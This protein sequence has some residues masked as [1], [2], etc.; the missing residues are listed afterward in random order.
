MAQ[1]CIA[2]GLLLLLVCVNNVIGLC[3][4]S[5]P[6]VTVPSSVTVKHGSTVNISSDSFRII[7]SSSYQCKIYFISTSTYSCGIVSPDVFDCNSFGHFS[8]THY[9]CD[10]ETENLDFAV[11][12]IS[13][14]QTVL[15]TKYVSVKVKVEDDNNPVLP[16][17]DKIIVPSDTMSVSIPLKLLAENLTCEYAIVSPMRLPYYG[18]VTGPTSL[19]LAC[20]SSHTF[21]Y[22]LHSDHR[23]PQSE[24]RVVAA[25]RFANSNTRFVQIRVVIDHANNVES[26]CSNTQGVLPLS[27]STYTPVNIEHLLP[28][29]SVA[30]ERDWKVNI[31]KSNHLVIFAI[32][33]HGQHVSTDLFTIEQLQNGLVTLCTTMPVFP[34]VPAPSEHHYTIHDVYGRP[35]FNGSVITRWTPLETHL[36]QVST[37][38]GINVLEGQSVRVTSDILEFI[39][40]NCSDLTI[41]IIEPPKH[42][43]FISAETNMTQ[44]EFTITKD[45]RRN[46]IFNHSGD[47]NFADRAIWEIQCYGNNIGK[48]LQ[49]IRVTVLD[50]SPP[51]LVSKSAMSVHAYEIVQI[52]LIELQASDVD[53]CDI[54]IRY[55]ISQSNGTLFSSKKEALNGS[56][57]GLLE[58]TQ[59]DIDSGNVWYRPPDDV[60]IMK[61]II[62]FSLSDNSSPPNVLSNQQLKINILKPMNI[63]AALEMPLNSD[64]IMKMPVV[65]IG[66]VTLLLPIHFS[67]FTEQ[68]SWLK[69]TVVVPPESGNLSQY[70]FTLEDLNMN[71]IVYRHYG[72]EH[73]CKDNFIFQMSNSSG[74]QLFGKLVIA[75]VNLNMTHDVSL[76]VSPL[77]FSNIRPALATNSITVLDSPVCIDHLLFNIETA[78]R[79][80]TLYINKSLCSIR[81]LGSG[82]WFSLQDVRNGFVT[83][84]HNSSHYNSSN[85][86]YVDEF[87]FSL[88][89][90]VGRL[91]LNGD[92]TIR[93]SIVYTMVDPVVVLRSPSTLY[94]CHSSSNYCYNLSSVNIDVKSQVA[95]DS[96]IIIDVKGLPSYGRLM[97]TNGRQSNTFT[98]L[99]LRNKEVIYEIDL[100][101][102]QNAISNDSFTFFVRVAAQRVKSQQSYVLTL[103]WNYIF[104]EE[105]KLEV[106]ETD[107][108]FSVTVR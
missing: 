7:F 83:Y 1:M 75:M 72:V 56:G 28:N 16:V 27:F 41:S 74:A 34:E 105:P 51:F 10:K 43:Q 21:E 84:E 57:N 53:S 18:N 104:M 90:P 29:C 14:N 44:T 78:P 15:N 91:T 37:N 32:T 99:E 33:S 94:P 96:E 3:Q 92:T 63:P 46:I 107:G 62:L 13:S 87:T 17:F 6:K 11:Y 70:Q 77:G 40:H 60:T 26:S 20:N 42:G 88:S 38:D 79:I 50:D 106:N 100:S 81:K 22:S 36:V 93:Y 4:P 97:N 67:W 76:Q 47:D 49:P 24:D 59:S 85:S 58:F 30:V 52:S 9:G 68:F 71:R 61:D 101:L 45:L 82:S 108:E 98:M 66:N 73:S 23:P 12:L 31:T 55:N 5:Q 86:S 2:K 25:V 102:W 69:I 19:W 8:Y 89:S 65:E 39:V 64:S 54:D 95:N 103:M 80:G 48:F 35:I